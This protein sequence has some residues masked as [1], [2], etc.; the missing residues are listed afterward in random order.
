MEKIALIIP[1]IGR[2]PSYTKLFFHSLKPNP[3]IHCFFLTDQVATFALPP[4]VTWMRM[5]LYDIRELASAQ[6]EVD[7]VMPH[8]YKLCDYKPAYG[9]ILAAHTVDYSHWAFGDMDLIFGN[10][11][12]CL[13]ENWTSY[14]VIS[15]RKEWISGSFTVLRNSPEVRDLFMKSNVW[16]DV[17]SSSKHYS[18]TEVN[19]MF[20]R[21]CKSGPSQIFE[22]SSHS[23]TRVVLANAER[24]KVHFETIIKESIHHDDCVH[25]NDGGISDASGRT[26]LHYHYISE[27]TLR[28]FMFPS[29]DEIPDEFY[30]TKLGFYLSEEFASRTNPISVTARKSKGA[31]NY[32]MKRMKKMQARYLGA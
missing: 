4:N 16:R 21:I 14:D 12:A 5:S 3:L 8:A 25:Y 1:W 31:Y 11:A 18:F 28:D 24:L 26:Y 17:Y 15:C 27:K 6:L 13:P 10:V 2:L 22:D 30:I 19:G 29:W 32:F 9:K 7:A 23:F 20:G